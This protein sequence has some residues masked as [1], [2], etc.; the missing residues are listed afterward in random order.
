MFFYIV[1]IR[2]F[3]ENDEKEEDILKNLQKKLPNLPLIY[4]QQNKQRNFS[5]SCDDIPDIMSIQ[6]NNDYWQVKE[7]ENNMIYLYAAYFDKR[8]IILKH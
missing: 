4:W 2:S 1:S 3:E 8:K 5:S 7:T 6:Y